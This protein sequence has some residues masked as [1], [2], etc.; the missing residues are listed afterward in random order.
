MLFV[1]PVGRAGERIPYATAALLLL[2][3]L[4]F[5][6]LWPRE[7]RGGHVVADADYVDASRRLAA[8][9]SAPDAG[10][11]TDDRAALDAA[12]AE[13]PFPSPALTAL[14]DK[15][16]TTLSAQSGPL[17]YRWGLEY[18]VFDARRR[19][20]SA[21]PH[22]ATPY[23]RWGFVAGASPVPGVITHQFLHAGFLHLLFNMV[24]F[25]IFGGL[26]EEIAG[27]GKMIALYL[28]TGVAGAFAQGVWGVP[29]GTV[30]VGASGAISGLMGYALAGAPRVKIRLFYLLILMLAPRYGVF[31]AP[32][33]F[34]VPLWASE[35]VLMGLLTKTSSVV[36]VGYGAH[37]G[38][39]AAGILLGL[40][41][42][43]TRKLEV[44][45][46]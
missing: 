3:V 16:Q 22:A 40:L 20:V 24:F 19:S 31:P 36:T 14:F 44:E 12:R 6:T 30:M 25:W 27:G 23:R 1:F 37:L 28:T 45:S 32:L 17:Q 38:G 5:F 39:L 29:A 2:N 11:S 42:R 33:W 46:E 35:Q 7:Q 26:V 15:V 10:L 34:F 18:P 4:L 9:L 21:A 43:P 8:V 41:W 13:V